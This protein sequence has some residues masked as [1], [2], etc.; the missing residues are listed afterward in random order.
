LV[1]YRNDGGGKRPRLS[2]TRHARRRRVLF[3]AVEARLLLCALHDEGGQGV[4][5]TFI[6]GINTPV[7]L[8]VDPNEPTGMVGPT[9]DLQSQNTNLF[10]PITN[11]ATQANGLP[12]LNS[13]PGAP[14]SI[15][16]D[17]DGDT[18][19]NTSAYSED[20]DLTTYNL[21]EQ[22]HIVEAWRQITAYFAMFDTNVTTQFVSSAPK[23]WEM[24]GNGAGGATGGYAYVGTFPNSTPEAFN[25]SGNATSRESGMAHELG[26]VFGLQ[27]QSSYDNLGVKINEYISATDSLHGAIMGVDYSGSVHKWFI[28]HSA[29][30]VTTLQDDMAVIAGKIKAKEPASGDGYRPDD[31]GN[32]IAT[33]S[34]LAVNGGLQYASGIIE[35]RTDVDAFSFT[36]TDGGVTIAAIPDAPS[37]VDTK[38]EIYDSAGNLVA[39]KDGATNDQQMTLPGLPAGTY[40]ALVSSHGD[41]GDQG[42]YDLSVRALPA[43]WQ[44]ADIGTTG[45]VGYTEFDPATNTFTNAGAGSAVSGTADSLH[46]VY[47]SLTG[48]GEIVARV[49][50]NTNTNASAK[51][52]L[53]IRDGLANNAKHAAMIL[54]PTGGAQFIYRTSLG[55]SA[56]VTNGV[57]NALPYWVRLVRAG[58]LFVGYISSDGV[59]WT[60]VSQATVAMSATVNIGVITSSLTTSTLDK[61]QVDSVAITGNTTPVAP[62]YN[63]LP[64]PT[65]LVAVPSATG[66]GATLTWSDVAGETGFN[67][68]RSSDGITYTQ[69]TTT[70]AAVLTYTDA[71]P[72]ARMRY[73]YKVQARDATG[74]SVPSA[75]ASTVT[76]P[77]IPTGLAI[78]TTTNS[79]NTLVIDWKDVSGDNG[80]RIERS[81]DNGLTWSTLATVGVNVP[82]YNNTG[83]PAGT[84]Y[85]YRVVALSDQGDTA[86]STA[87]TGASRLPAVTGMG[88]DTIAYNSIT[89]HWIDIAGETGY[90]IDRSL[91][92]TTWST[93]VTGLAA[94]STTY[95]DTTVSPLKEY[96]Y[97]VYGTTAQALSLDPSAYIFGA[98]PGNPPLPAPWTSADIGTIYGRGASG[99]ASG[100]YTLI[101]SGSDIAGTADSFHYTSQPLTGDGQIIAKI[102]TLENT[103][104][105]AK[106]GVMIR[107]ST[108]AGAAYI[109]VFVTPTSGLVL[110]TRTSTGGATTV[111][112]VAG[113]AAP[114]WV[115]VVRSGT[116][117]SGYYS[118]D[119]I[120]W[121]QVGAN[122]T[123]SLGAG[124][125]IGMAS[126]S[127]S[128]T[129]LS[130]ATVTNVT[131]N[132]APTLAS[133]AA[134]T[135]VTNQNTTN[136]SALASDDQGEANLTYTWSA[137]TI[138]SG[139]ATPTYTVNG[140]NA[141]KNTTAT[142]YKS[143]FY[144]FKVTITD[145]GGLS[146]TSSVSVNV[147]LAVPPTVVIA[148]EADPNPVVNA[149]A[150]ALSVLGADDQG[151]ANLIYAWSTTS[152][153]NGAIAPTFTNSGSN[154]AKNSSVTFYKDGDYQLLVTITDPTGLAVTSSVNVTVTLPAPPT[155]AAPAAA[156]PN[157]VV[158]GTTAALSVLGADDQGE[159]NLTYTWTATAVPDGAG[160]PT[161]SINGTNAAKNTTVTFAQ[162][163]N[164]TFRVTITD[165][166]GLS[167][168][169]S[170]NVSVNAPTPPDVTASDF[171][172]HRTLSFTFSSDVGKSLGVDDLT[173]QPLA[174]LGE[175]LS[176]VS[177]DWNAD[178]K[179]A[180]FTFASD[181]ADGDYRATL[182]AAG[183]TDDYGVH[184][185][186]DKIYGFFAMVGDVNRDRSVDFLDLAIMAQNYNSPAPGYAQGDVNGDGMVDFL[187]LAIL[188]QHYNTT[189]LAVPASTPAAPVTASAEAVVAPVTAT[190]PVTTTT[191]T[192]PSPSKPT[193]PPA[194]P[195]KVKPSKPAPPKP[196]T[197]PPPPVKP[198]FSTSRINI[199]KDTDA[200]VR[201]TNVMVAAPKSKG[202]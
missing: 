17:F 139:A 6:D 14:T 158:S 192:V 50:Q 37:G 66:T 67:V 39:A 103:D 48:D 49:T 132:F 10:N 196:V 142:F 54:T 129:L 145:A 21:T 29:T 119:G 191:T 198:V 24:I 79:T 8:H 195:V 171:D 202:R 26:H 1:I 73:F 63:S 59:N 174:A 181:F 30:G 123:L 126:T 95:T 19:S 194:P 137:T 65:D 111:T 51:V 27:H 22:T 188:A 36:A 71:T 109:G 161:F 56:T 13:L 52:G 146:I 107:A 106:A 88:L 83:L 4:H 138:P 131:T 110:Q 94:N 130:T 16:L 160:A 23:A 89:L 80:Y 184:L 98:T 87:I 11:W 97:R 57:T 164:Y 53:D 157:P 159:A 133:G 154:A 166:N 120:T 93:L 179:T 34:P 84:T 167:V 47:Q 186:A 165:A 25:A 60:Q 116:T 134:A 46:Y 153:P 28:G 44:S 121:T 96:Y 55:G 68:L 58:N 147:T 200:N 72:G 99:Y 69:I 76:R 152:A 40:Y 38:L 162:P 62:V 42:M 163:G 193:I 187:D 141:A 18:G 2:A 136:L 115:K 35:R 170:V 148:A 117:F 199:A 70:A 156:D 104:A 124:A 177:V 7:E 81:S 105:N 75:V 189:L 118:A 102:A 173:V 201:V 20:A 9:G 12:I 85:S 45:L 178:T 113:I 101:S 108:A 64:A 127:H 77:A 122:L 128:T 61:G 74:S 86:P 140:A 197:P 143:G 5:I 100:I 41:Y 175:V 92:G 168:T 125:S 169:S 90:R 149:N 182:G 155:V 78:H 144:T 33:A 112:T 185:A 135:A 82:S 183:I 15:Y 180:T 176:P 151:E 43:G 91:D 114:Y 3:E 190:A 150:A 32:T 172:F 31:F